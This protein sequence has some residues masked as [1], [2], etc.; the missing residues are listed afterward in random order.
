[1]S[2]F[3]NLDTLADQLYQEGLKKAQRESEKIINEARK[4]A[5]E[6][7][8]EAAK[9]AAAITSQAKKDAKRHFTTVQSEIEQKAKQVKQDLKTEIQNLINARVL[10]H[11]LKEVLSD[12]DFVKELITSSLNS[13][14]GGKEVE[15]LISESFERVASD[16]QAKIQKHLSGLKVTLSPH[17]DT[18]FKIEDTEKGYILSFTDSDFK[19][20]FEPYLSDVVR[21]ILFERSE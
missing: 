4:K 20:L 17:L 12:Q 13:W 14:N 15:L 10:S 5:E 1:M 7:L 19:A 11:P 6:Q 2:E 9:E 16:V 21:K 3:K 18:G 8:A